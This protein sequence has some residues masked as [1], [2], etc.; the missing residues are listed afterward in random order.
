MLSDISPADFK[1]ILLKTYSW[2]HSLMFCKTA[3]ILPTL[4]TNRQIMSH[5]KANV[6]SNFIIY[7]AIVVLA[8]S[9]NIV[10]SCLRENNTYSIKSKQFMY[11]I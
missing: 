11:Y 2:I 7:S 4:L 3:N 8:A 10:I 1:T 9:G 6:K 5:C